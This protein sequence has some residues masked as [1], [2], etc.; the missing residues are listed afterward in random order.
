MNGKRSWLV[1]R[2][3]LMLLLGFDGCLEQSVK[4]IVSED[5]SCER[6]IAVSADSGR[7]PTT[8]LPLPVD[9]SWTFRWERKEGKS[10]FSWVASKRFTSLGTLA[11][12]KPILDQPGKIRIALQAGR[13]FRWFYTYISYRETY[14]RFTPFK[15]TSPGDV[16]TEDEIKRFTN[17]EGGDTLESKVEE[18]KT[19]N[20]TD[21]FLY[22]LDT[23]LAAQASPP[24]SPAQ[25]KSQR[26]AILHALSARKDIKETLA[27]YLPEA[28]KRNFFR[29]SSMALTAQGVE[30]MRRLFVRVLGTPSARL[31]PLEESWDRAIQYATGTAAE[32]AEGEFENVVILPGLFLDTNAGNLKGNTATWSFKRDQIELTDYVMFAES[33]VVNTWAFILSGVVA[34]GFL[35]LL[36]IP[37]LRSGRRISI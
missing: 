13:S 21:Y 25:V 16:M 9:T 27:E 24:V 20:Y 37:L 5:G 7:V 31:L 26:G 10:G 18:W 17:G 33:R 14:H 35:G 4:T 12:E 15:R 2:A 32:E 23:L 36:L 22:S 34:V 1:V 28:E 8:K 3:A 6:T 30:A 19:R 29:D 11:A